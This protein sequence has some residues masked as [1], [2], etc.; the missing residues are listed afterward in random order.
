MSE[1]TVINV[2]P[3]TPSDGDKENGSDESTPTV[4]TQ[5]VQEQPLQ[6]AKEDIENEKSSMDRVIN[7]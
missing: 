6:L 1:L 4:A 7:G 2:K 3:I 5:S